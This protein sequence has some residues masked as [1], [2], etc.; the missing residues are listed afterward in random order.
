MLEIAKVNA[1]I[2]AAK[3]R[4]AKAEREGD[5]ALVLACTSLLTQLMGLLK[6][7][8]KRERRLEEEK[9]AEAPAGMPSPFSDMPLQCVQR[10]ALACSA[11]N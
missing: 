3:E 8:L 6:E 5:K 1:D 4:L 11:L 2:A 7:L 9:R 10:R